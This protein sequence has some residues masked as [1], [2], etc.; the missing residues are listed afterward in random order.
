MDR[1]R[2][3]RRGFTLVELLVV[4]TI[5]GMLMGLL[6]PAVQAAREAARRNTCSNNQHQLGLALI[7]YESAKRLFP[8]FHMQLRSPSWPGA[9][10]SVD[11]SWMTY[12]LPYLERT[13]I[14]NLWN[15]ST[16]NT[17][18]S[19]YYGFMTTPVYLKVFV[20]PSDPPSSVNP[21][22]DGP[23]AYQANGHVL[24]DDYLITST[25]TWPANKGRSID[26]ISA[27]DGSTQ[28]LLLSENQSNF[29]ITIGT[30]SSGT[31]QKYHNWWGYPQCTTAGATGG[32][33]STST[34]AAYTYA[35]YQISFGYGG[36]SLDTYPVTQALFLNNTINNTISNPY[37][38]SVGNNLESNHG[39]GAVATFCDGHTIFLRNDISNITYEQLCN[40][41]DLGIPNV[42][43]NSANYGSPGTPGFAFPPL[44]ESNYNQ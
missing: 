7:S 6:L 29:A 36:Y 11:T 17:Q 42:T 31:V 5:I 40:P 19:P 37:P 35:P 10:T 1:K 28:T 16:N 21:G 15:Y 44:D 12:L 4:I 30:V 27:K 38:T 26:Y 39:G 18:A 25:G 43:N 22:V 32:T 8:G 24:R 23:A 2:N 13:D 9:N 33:A 41:N 34:G 20:C 14:W 3:E